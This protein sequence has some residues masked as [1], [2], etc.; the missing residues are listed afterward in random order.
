LLKKR[1][2]TGCVIVLACS[3]YRL[4]RHNTFLMK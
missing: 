1:V 3:D 4:N 2:I